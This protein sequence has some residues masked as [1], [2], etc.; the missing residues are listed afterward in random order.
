[1]TTTTLLLANHHQSSLQTAQIV[2]ENITIIPSIIS[3]TFSFITYS[4]LGFLRNFS[5][6]IADLNNHLQFLSLSLIS[7]TTDLIH[8]QQ[9]YELILLQFV[10]LFLQSVMIKWGEAVEGQTLC[11]RLCKSNSTG[12]KVLAVQKNSILIR[13]TE[14]PLTAL[15]CDA[16]ESWQNLNFS[17]FH[18]F[19]G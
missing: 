2:F 12:W 4:A 9:C 10:D 16:F 8:I 3:V 18:P 6:F 14:K 5:I 1:M 19:S 7:V 13:A 11:L 15:V 17:H